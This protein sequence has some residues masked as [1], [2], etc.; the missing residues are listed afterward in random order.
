VDRGHVNLLSVI[1]DAVRGQ[2]N[3][4]SISA[5]GSAEASA[6]NG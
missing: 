4:L 1:D 3:P 6:G 5:L 2:V